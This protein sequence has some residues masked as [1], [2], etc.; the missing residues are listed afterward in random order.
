MNLDALVWLVAGVGVGMGL[1]LLLLIGYG[2]LERMRLGRRLKRARTIE[3][4]APQPV[5]AAVALAPV[6]ADEAE[7]EPRLPLEEVAPETVDETPLV[8]E[9]DEPVAPPAE[10]T[11]AEPK[12]DGPKPFVLIESLEPEELPPPA[13]PTEVRAKNVEDIFAQAFAQGRPARSEPEKS[14]GESKA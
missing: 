13:S 11:A 7:P 4:L 12:S 9:P 6:V 3:A 2:W 5:A 10:E 1:S 14:E 8:V